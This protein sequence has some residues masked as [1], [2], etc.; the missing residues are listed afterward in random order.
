MK[1]IERIEG[2]KV[3]LDTEKD[4]KLWDG[5]QGRKGGNSPTRWIDL[6]MHERKDGAKTFFLAHYTQWQGESSYVEALDLQDAQ[7]FAEEHA[8][9]LLDD[10]EEAY[11]KEIGL[12]DMSGVE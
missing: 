4:A 5:H 12:I 2:S 9:D 8:Q 6:H 10:Y 3:L 7:K 11:L 1:K